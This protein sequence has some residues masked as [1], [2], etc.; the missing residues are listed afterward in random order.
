[1]NI[2]FFG[3]ARMSVGNFIVLECPNC[4]KA[5]GLLFYT[6]A[7]TEN[8]H[9][10]EFFYTLKELDSE[11]AIVSSLNGTPATCRM[12]ESV[13]TFRGEVQVVRAQINKSP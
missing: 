2:L 11:C 10:C 12:C 7:P 6:P 8:G 13:Y 3:A 5:E 1:M 4:K 9:T